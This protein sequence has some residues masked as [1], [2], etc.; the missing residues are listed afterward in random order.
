MAS[1]KSSYVPDG[2]TV[3][4]IR[5]QRGWSQETLAEKASIAV[6]TIRKIEKGDA[7]EAR[8]LEAV[9]KCFRLNDWHELLTE[10]EKV[11]LG[12][13]AD[14]GASAPVEPAPT[15]QPL[16]NPAPITD[17]IPVSNPPAE[18]GVTLDAVLIRIDVTGYVPQSREVD[19]PKSHTFDQYL[20]E[21]VTKRATP[22]R[23]R[24]IKSTWDA[25]LLWCER[26]AELLEFVLELMLRQPIAHPDEITPSFRVL[27]H[28]DYFAFSHDRAGAVDG[29]HESEAIRFFGLE[30]TAHRNRL[31]VTP[32]LFKGLQ[33]L[34]PRDATHH[35]ESLPERL[36]G[37]E[38][39]PRQIHVVRLPVTDQNRDLE[40][41]AAYRSVRAAFA[42]EVQVIPVFGN[43]YDPIPMRENF[44]NLTLDGQRTRSRGNYVRWDYPDLRRRLEIRKAD[45]TDDVTPVRSGDLRRIPVA[46]L[47]AATATAVIAGLPGAGKTT[48]LRHFAWKALDENPHTV[49]VFAEA[50]YLHESHFGTAPV[51]PEAASRL[52]FRILAAL[53][54]RKGER[55]DA[56]PQAVTIQIEELA[57]TLQQQFEERRAVVLI[58]AL[59]EAP[60]P[61]LREKLAA[62]ANQLMATLPNNEG[63]RPAFAGRCYLSLRAAELDQHDFTAGPVFLVN[64]LDLEQMR[65]IARLRLGDRSPTYV[66]F[67]DEIWRRLDV[68]KIAGTPLTAMLMVFFFEVEDRFSRR[69]DIYR[70]L[71]LFILDRAWQRIKDGNFHTPK[72]GLNPFFRAVRRPDYLK[73]HPEIAGQLVALAKVACQLLYH[74]AT[75]GEAGRAVSRREFRALLCDQ[76]S[77]VPVAEIEAWE[78]AWQ[79]QNLILPAGADSWA[80]M[81]S[82]VLEFLAAE[83]LRPVLERDADPAELAPVFDNP[84]CDHLETLPI[85]CSTDH[86]LPTRVLTLL[87]RH[88][89]RFAFGATLPYRCLVELETTDQSLLTE[90]KTKPLRLR[91]EEELAARPGIEWAYAHLTRWVTEPPGAD[92]P[93]KVTFLDQRLADLKELAPLP[94]DV[95]ARRVA[96]VWRSDGGS[97]ARKQEDLLRKIVT[98]KVWS[99]VRPP[100]KE[101]APDDIG[102]RSYLELLRKYRGTEFAAR[103]ATLQ[104][105]ESGEPNEE[106][107][108]DRPN[109]PADKNLA[110]YRANNDPDIA[111]FF[112]SPNFRQGGAIRAIAFSP[113][114]RVAVSG[115]TD[116][117]LVLWDTGT[118]REVRTFEGHSNTVYA[119]AFS[120]DGCHVLSGSSDDTL[121]LWDA[122]T[123]QEVRTFEGHSGTVYACAFS[124]DG[125]HV[126]SGSFDGTLKLWDAGTGQ[127][128][129]TFR[130][131]SRAVYACAFNPTAPEQFVAA[132]SSGVLVMMRFGLGSPT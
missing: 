61:A 82:T 115:A 122:G 18:A 40:L 93:A 11:R 84:T 47:Y 88:P 103:V 44:L 53:F 22:H 101:T 112:G 49:I 31:V 25:A 6:R 97:L 71:V 9:A 35:V 12:L 110:Y 107:T 120:P 90:F 39:S 60:T 75:D 96:D 21:E 94:R 3:R 30:K 111:G 77:E 85:L 131:H 68:Q 87:G 105:A 37:A 56:F 64:S 23:V 89:N 128:V 7:V 108:L 102:A 29:V 43:L 125:S 38:D 127:E 26:P 62:L 130:G 126:L 46:E 14:S 80:F 57:E 129:H 91:T 113:D 132:R 54:L 81:H 63:A 124:P 48:I 92:E 8:S 34:L 72:A 114:G 1:K 45:P 106:L 117:S 4:R 2:E 83:A 58:D 36:K 50:K 70:L 79:Q 66:R 76:C 98:E 52:P 104:E 16:T 73:K 86:P 51:G 19:A 42:Q 33:S 116:G 55:P 20:R 65:H 121:K 78:S 67:D 74:D 69:Y 123:G 59:D 95:L 15:D 28:K 99:A 13:A 10:T 5:D 119:C 24:W 17:P 32:Y 41:P 100:E 118:G 27:A 109:H